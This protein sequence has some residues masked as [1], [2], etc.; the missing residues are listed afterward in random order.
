M[1]ILSAAL[2][3]L[4]LC[5]ALI[6]SLCFEDDAVTIWKD[7]ARIAAALEAQVAE[8]KLANAAAA[9]LTTQAAGINDKL[10]QLVMLLTPEP[11]IVGIGVT[12]N[13]PTPR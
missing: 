11:E 4:L 13:P 10:A 1:L 9:E 5:V 12:E 2:A 8:Q 7:L 3:C 6:V